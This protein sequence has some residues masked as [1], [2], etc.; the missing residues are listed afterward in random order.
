M[1]H[2]IA[3]VGASSFIGRNFARLATEKGHDVCCLS[4]MPVEGE[5]QWRHCDVVAG[6]L[7]L[8]EET[9]AVVYLA[10]SAHYREFPEKADDLF[11]VN[12]LGAVRTA[13]AALHTHCR[14]FCYASTGNVYAPSFA[15]LSED[16]PVS[17]V[18]PYGLSK[19]MAE[20]ALQCFSPRLTVLNARIFGVYGPG[21][22]AMLPYTL[23]RRIM[24]NEPISLFLTG[25]QDNNGLRV[26]FIY[27]DDLARC[28]LAIVEKA[29]CGDVL[30]PH[31]NVAGPV[32][33]SIRQMAETMAFLLGREAR[34][35]VQTS[36]RTFDLVADISM[37]EQFVVPCFTPL[38]NG[39]RSVCSFF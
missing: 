18:N 29:L 16:H 33:V 30:P 35:E 31:I 34:F 14:F 38:E 9:E 3:I 17:R 32:P 36:P 22:T 24:L 4:R 23:L 10:Q 28:L 20:E 26:S 37:L 13:Q 6:P 21:Q 7:A 19:V 5:G 12:V 1:I 27:N 25:E 11:G 2:S 39:L 15:P 8:P